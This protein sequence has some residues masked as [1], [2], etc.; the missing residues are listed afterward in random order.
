MAAATE[1]AAPAQAAAAQQ[2]AQSSLYVGDLDRDVTEATLF[3]LF[4][5]VRRRR[6]RRAARGARRAACESA[7]MRTR[8]PSAHAPAARAPRAMRPPRARGG[9]VLRKLMKEGEMMLAAGRKA[10]SPTRNRASTGGSTTATANAS[11]TATAATPAGEREDEG[12]GIGGASSSS[13]SL[14]HPLAEGGAASL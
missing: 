5:T 2:T 6:G 14:A 9:G 13:S 11:A 10:A 4:S 8:P 1:S 12:A 7:R 3:E